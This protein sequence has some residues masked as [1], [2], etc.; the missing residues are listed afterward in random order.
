MDFSL[1]RIAPNVPNVTRDYVRLTDVLDDTIDARVFQGLHFRSADVQAAR[2][3][4]QVAE[5]VDEHAFGPVLGRGN[6]A[7]DRHGT[8][9]VPSPP[10]RTRG[11]PVSP[12]LACGLVVR[13]Q[14]LEER[15]PGAAQAAAT[16]P[17]GAEP[18]TQA[19]VDAGDLGQA[20]VPQLVVDDEP[21][22][23]RQRVGLGQ[24]P[25]EEVGTVA[26]DRQQLGGRRERSGVVGDGAREAGEQLGG[27]GVH[28]RS[29]EREREDVGE[30]DGRGDGQGVPDCVP[31]MM[32]LWAARP[33]TS[34]SSRAC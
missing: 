14:Q 7:V 20:P 22:H 28:P 4:R 18:H 12:E 23:E 2:L 32:V 1:V 31:M 13:L 24:H 33:S 34:N 10:R 30:R 9:S 26:L 21:R 15:R 11:R 8:C 3:G 19:E 5:W 25:L 29:D 17:R 6:G 27:I 16:Q